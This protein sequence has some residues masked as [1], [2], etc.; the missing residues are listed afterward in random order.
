[1][2]LLVVGASKGI[3]RLFAEVALASGHKV[4]IAARNMSDPPSG[5][6]SLICD[7]RD[8]E[9]C[10]QLVNDALAFLGGLDGLVYA[11]GISPLSPLREATAKLWNDVF[12]TNI[13]G[14]ATIIRFAIDELVVN[15]G[16]LIFVSSTMVGNP[17]PG[18][19]PYSSSRAALEELANGLRVEYPSLRVT[20]VTI[21]PTRTGFESNW[22]P[23]ILEAAVHTWRRGGFLKSDS[24]SLDAKKVAE[25]LLAI[26]NSPVRIENIDLLP[27]RENIFRKGE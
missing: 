9:S 2:R 24:E 10:E 5:A 16:R 21:G 6:H 11:A 7:V 17:W 15:R 14:A 8:A 22:D 27:D 13:I 20:T 26:I 19:I 25:S 18:L 23:D 12:N 1:M 3:G 4:V